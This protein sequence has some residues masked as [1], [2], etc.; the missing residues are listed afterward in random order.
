MNRDPGKELKRIRM[1]CICEDDEDD[2]SCWIWGGSVSPS[3]IPTVNRLVDGKCRLMSARR[4]IF[5]HVLGKTLKKGDLVTTSCKQQK[6]LNP[7]HLVKSNQSKVQTDNNRDNLALFAKRSAAIRAARDRKGLGK[8]LTPEKADIARDKSRRA[9]EV[10]AE[11]G[12]SPSMVNRIRSG[13]AWKPR[14]EPRQTAMGFVAA[15]LASNDS[16]TR[17]AA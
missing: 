2:D 4:W 12:I 11:L 1:R 14:G 17:R 8:K 16:S 7:K 15:Q 9:D 3:G 6:C 13:N 10:A 5:S